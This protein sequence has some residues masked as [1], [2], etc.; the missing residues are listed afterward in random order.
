MK[1]LEPIREPVE[2]DRVAVRSGDWILSNIW[3]IIPTI[4]ISICIVLVI[5]QGISTNLSESTIEYH[6]VVG[7]MDNGEYLM[8]SPDGDLY[9]HDGNFQDLEPGSYIM[10][11]RRTE[12]NPLFDVAYII[13]G[14]TSFGSLWLLLMLASDTRD[15][16]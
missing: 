2:A 13:L 7:V 14:I 8:E 1:K 9:I 12:P 16:E 3:L 10:I 15:K 4:L 6:R 5:F 11:Q